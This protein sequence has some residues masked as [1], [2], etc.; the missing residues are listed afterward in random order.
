LL[1]KIKEVV[2]KIKNT[3]YIIISSE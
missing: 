3:V 1:T 2:F